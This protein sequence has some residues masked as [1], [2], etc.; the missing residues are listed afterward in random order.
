MALAAPVSHGPAAPIDLRQQMQQQQQLHHLQQQ[1]LHVQHLHKQ[2]VPHQQGLPPQPDPRGPEDASPFVRGQCVRL[3]S[4][5]VNYQ[6]SG[7]RNG[8]LVVCIH[9][10]NGSISSFAYLVPWLCQAGLQVLCFDL[11]GFGLSASSWPGRLDLEK[12]VEQVRALL[13]ALRIP[14]QRVS[15]LG[16]SMGGVI[17]VEFVNRFPERILRLLLVAPGGLMQMS[18][19]PCRPLLFGCLRKRWGGCLTAFATLLACCCS[20]CVR[21]YLGTDD[22]LSS[23][24]QPD[25]RE[26]ENFRLESRQNGQRILWNVPR[27]VNS[28]LRVLQRMPLWEDDFEESYVR[29][30]EGG[31]PVL[32][33]WGTGDCTVPVEECIQKVRK[34]MG[35]CGASLIKVPEAGHGLM[36]EDAPQVANIASAWFSESAD[37]S[38]LQFLHH[39]RIFPSAATPPLPQT[40]G[41]SSV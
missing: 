40:M 14:Q 41:H 31:V 19:T 20:F 6:L 30:A 7:P 2:P 13:E 36:L 37:P 32:L 8:P 5:E 16:F 18:A 29:L 17:A 34:I 1:Q 22:K 12:Y 4:G 9:G 11:Y 27:T 15:I 10:L 38:W 28:Y 39:W 25:V 3:K 35:P 33:L 24:F 21:R 23:K 26:P